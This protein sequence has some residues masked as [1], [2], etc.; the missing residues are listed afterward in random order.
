[1]VVRWCSFSLQQTQPRYQLQML[2][3]E[4]PDTARA[5]RCGLGLF[6]PDLAAGGP[7]NRPSLDKHHGTVPVPPTRR[8]AD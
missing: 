3:R 5:A 2:L 8:C 6:A 1:M 4:S 7:G